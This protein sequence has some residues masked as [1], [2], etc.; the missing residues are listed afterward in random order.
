MCGKL[1]YYLT[2]FSQIRID[3]NRIV[4]PQQ[5]RHGSPYKPFLLLSILDHIA[6]G[7]ITTNFIGPSFELTQTFLDYINLLPTLISKRATMS[8]PFYHLNSA[9]FWNLIPQPG[10]EHRKGLT[11]GSMKRLRNLYLGARFNNDLFPLLLMERSREKLKAVLLSTYFSEELQAAV[12]QRSMLN[13]ASD[14]YSFS[15]LGIREQQPQYA[16][17]SEGSATNEKIRDFGFRKAIVKLYDH[18]CALCG[19]KMR[20]P[21]GH[22]V[23]DAAHIIPW[24]KSK[25]DKP[26]NGMALCKLCHWSFDEG[27]MSV[28]KQYQVII[29]PAVIKENNLPGHIMTLAERPMFRPP[30][31]RFWPDQENFKWHRKECFLKKQ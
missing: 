29:S 1:D 31:N 27:L 17:T 2:E 25:N 13:R 22:T 28:D 24:S 7:R 5:T 12:A 21:E 15:L 16:L 10:T 9:S 18:R 30:E 3:K 4:W 11:I 20:T 6:A 14:A 26:S 19:I 23:V 8:Y